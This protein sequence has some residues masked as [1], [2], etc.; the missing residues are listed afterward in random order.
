MFSS[1][2]CG[3][4][5][6]INPGRVTPD[7]KDDNFAMLDKLLDT[8]TTTAD[9]PSLSSRPDSPQDDSIRGDPIDEWVQ[10]SEHDGGEAA[11]AAKM[12]AV[13][14]GPESRSVSD[15]NG[16]AVGEQE[17]NSL[18]HRFCEGDDD[19]IVDVLLD[20]FATSFSD[21]SMLIEALG[22]R[23]V[24]G[25][26]SNQLSHVDGATW[27]SPPSSGD[28]TDDHFGSPCLTA[29]DDLFKKEV[30]RTKSDM[31]DVPPK[32]AKPEAGHSTQD[33]TTNMAP[34][35]NTCPTARECVA[36][37]LCEAAACQDGSALL[38][39]L[40]DVE[41]FDAMRS[42]MRTFLIRV[43][44]RVLGGCDSDD[45]D[46]ED[47]DDCSVWTCQSINTMSAVE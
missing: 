26:L 23:G 20:K 8:L 34:S 29:W 2:Q 43:R 7:D 21:A 11:N 15:S 39:A 16:D 44:R 46:I 24:F 14:T 47:D 9:G 25:K 31:D 17:L 45:G 38:A 27:A 30:N 12:P 42:F 5:L 28:G 3:N 37:E 10:M 33:S 22:G 40:R 41:D 1:P 6:D 35:S 36:Q 19:D 13:Q 4:I 32:V 18:L